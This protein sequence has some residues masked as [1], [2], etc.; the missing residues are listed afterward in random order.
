MPTSVGSVLFSVGVDASGLGRGLDEARRSA[1]NQ[2]ISIPLIIIPPRVPEIPPITIPPVVVPPIE[3]PPVDPSPAIVGFQALADAART[4][5]ET[6]KG[7][8]TDGVQTFIGLEASLNSF[9][10]VAQASPEQLNAFKKEAIAVGIATSKTATESAAAG[11]ELAKLGFDADFTTKNLRGLVAMAEATG[12]SVAISARIV[13]AGTA[14]YGRSAKDIADLVAASS[15]A[16]G[17]KAPDFLQ[18]LSK[19][20]AVAKAN[21]QDLE[22][23]A[24]TFGLIKQAGFEAETASTALKVIINRLSAPSTKKA[25]DAMEQL[26]V[27]IRDSTTG[28]MRNLIELVPEFRA[29]LGNLR[30]DKKAS[31][32]REIFGDEGGPAFLALM[33]TAQEKVETVYAKINAASKGN[34]GAGAAMENQ[35]ALQQGLGYALEAKSGTVDALKTEIGEGLAP[36]LTQLTNK[37][38][39]L[40]SAFLNAPPALK[41]AV[42]GTVALATAVSGLIVGY[43]VL[44]KLQII[45]TAQ[46]IAGA[47]ATTAG[48]VVTKA[49]S[50]VRTI[51]AIATTEVTVALI[52]EKV[53][54][55][56]NTVAAGAYSASQVGL[57]ASTNLLGTSSY[58]AAGGLSAIA[59][60]A[61]L[62]LGPLA[63]LGGAIGLIAVVKKTQEMR[64]LNA[65]LDDLRVKT[66]IVGKAGVGSAQDLGNAQR[67]RDKATTEGRGLT[68]V[69]KEAEKK[70][71]SRADKTLPLLK[72]QLAEAEVV[73]EAKAGLFGIGKDEAEAQNN[74]RA[75]AIGQ[76]N[77]Q[78]E[79]VNRQKSAI[80]ASEATDKKKEQSL[81]KLPPTVSAVSR[82]LKEQS[83]ALDEQVIKQKLA[84][85]ADLESGK[86]N[87]QEAA[88]RRAE[89]SLNAA[90]QKAAF[91]NKDIE[92]LGDTKN[93]KPKEVE[94]LKALQLKAQKE[95]LKA[96]QEANKARATAEEERKR[97]ELKA[98]EGRFKSGEQAIQKD[99][100][101]ATLAAKQAELGGASAE[102]TSKKIEAIQTSQT[103][104]EIGLLAQKLTATK[105]LQASGVITAKESADRQAQVE[106]ELSNKTIALVE[107]QIAAKKKAAVDAIEARLSEQKLPL[108]RQAADLGVK[109]QNLDLSGKQAAAASGVNDAQAKLDQQRLGFQLQFAELAG[110]TAKQEELKEAIYQKQVNHLA[111]SQA[112]QRASVGLA[113]QQQAIELQRQEIVAK[114]AIIEAEAA[115]AKAVATG[116][117]ENEI[118]GLSQALGLRKQAAD[119]IGKV[120]ANQAQVNALEDK[121]L[122]IEQQATR[123]NLEQTRA[124]EKQKEARQ[125]A[126]EQ[127]EQNAKAQERASKLTTTKDTLG[128]RKAELSGT[129]SAQEASKQIE[130]IGVKTAERERDILEKKLA[131]TDDLRAKGLI[132][133]KEAADREAQIQQ[134]L[135]QANLNLIEK[136]L[137]AKKKAATD[138]IEAR[139]SERK[140]PL[141]KQA[142]D[143]GVKGQDLDF[144]AK[145]QGAITGVLEAQSK[146]DQQRLG[147]QLQLA[148]L[149][150]NTAQQEQ[151]KEAIY[152][153]QLKSLVQSQAQQKANVGLARQQQAIELQRQEITAKIG[154][155]EAEASLAKAKANGAA[156]SEIAT[157][158]QALG[159]RNQALGQISKARSAQAEINSLE[160]KKLA[161]EQKATRENLEQSRAIEK[162]KEARQ[163]IAEKI[164]EA[165]KAQERISKLTTTTDTLAIRKAELSGSLSAEDAAKQ[166]EVVQQRA[167]GREI[168]IMKNKLVATRQLRAQGIITAKE[169]A[170]REGQIQQELATANLGLIEKQLDAKRKAT[171]AAIEIQLAAQKQGL[172]NELNTLDAQKFGLDQQ[173]RK[174]AAAGG[175]TSAVSDLEKQRLEFQL[176]LADASGDA[177]KSEQLKKQIYDQQVAAL[178]VQQ[179]AQ[180]QSLA[181]SQKQQA[182]EL[183][184][185]KI[186]AQIALFESQAAIEKAKATGAAPREIAALKQVQGFREQALAQVGESEKA[187]NE[188]NQLEQQR[189]NIEQQGGRERLTQQQQLEE[190]RKAAQ[191]KKDSAG[192][193]LGST[194]AVQSSNVFDSFSNAK[195]ALDQTKVAKE[196]EDKKQQTL[197]I[198]AQTA[199]IQALGAVQAEGLKGL[200]FE[201]PKV[202]PVTEMTPDWLKGI[203]AELSKPL[204]IAKSLPMSSLP[205]TDA[206]ATVPDVETANKALADA[207]RA[208][209][210][211]TKKWNAEAQA[212][213][214]AD[215]RNFAKRKGINFNTEEGKVK[216]AIGAAEEATL[217]GLQ[218]SERARAKFGEPVG[219]DLKTFEGGQTPMSEFQRLQQQLEGARASQTK[220]KDEASK[221]KGLEATVTRIYEILAKRLGDVAPST[222]PPVTPKVDTEAK[223]IKMSLEETTGNIYK[224]LGTISDT[225][226]KNGKSGVGNLTVVSQNPAVE[227]AEIVSALGR[228]R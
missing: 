156:G 129:I 211:Y 139:L 66:D 171:T 122:S 193:S 227:C 50:A 36:F 207:Q 91:V 201:A 15:T 108:E 222:Q 132:S 219:G 105:Q 118:A 78:I 60:S 99:T 164:E 203:S 74:A 22:T 121:K 109:S 18:V 149:A 45:K 117:S 144:V 142:A 161:I 82:A 72:Q 44:E 145:K 152:Q 181:I 186:Q 5:F 131:T 51:Y 3:I 191:A 107:K 63:A 206:V 54:L 126:L 52:A 42:E 8:V 1:G 137:A 53:A 160:D 210:D 151:L 218:E 10:S 11:V 38:N 101:G 20:G 172:E 192:G 28:E 184:R 104:K 216:A 103:E 30:P 106:E 100:S 58:F 31:I 56:L 7:F 215:A 173:S 115:L 136:E 33:G 188:I 124:L 214:E 55:I 187:Q 147:F 198:T 37:Q 177:T 25:A 163:K 59:T 102:A 34:T 170:D 12:T 190:V 47:A 92:A 175:V 133:A 194:S 217:G 221:P 148:D 138:A 23:L 41:T 130:A 19:A 169:A 65:S 127:I 116:A 96:E 154:I 95:V 224:L 141:E 174:Q 35:K 81:V 150:D 159:L 209:E 155:L 228:R 97:E 166:I 114:I 212:N 128:V 98:F 90:T 202:A 204:E 146:L 143:L 119:Q 48:I 85:E 39:E 111:E 4:T 120:K 68:T 178:A 86:I 113:R 125:K 196:V 67:T 6:I 24:A 158:N 79:Q 46:E 17:L 200:G 62:A 168:T 94:K 134:D 84:I 176:A 69:E 70:A 225:L 9:R 57:A 123:E 80:E 199:I 83:R 32:T 226:I 223:Q 29:A 135:A 153:Q 40:I 197:T 208:M 213:N 77:M 14:I 49:A 73:P 93:A 76:I 26:G 88:K 179:Q 64:E 112:Q 220:A 110:N 195:L 21:N 89:I 185:Q 75:A 61:A 167:A 71:I 165:L 189:L 183:Q 13:G 140:L 205:V 27:S 180:Q 87:K 182:I 162:Q 2:S 157:L 16:A 43:T